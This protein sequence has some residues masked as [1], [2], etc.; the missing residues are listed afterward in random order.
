MVLVPFLLHQLQVY[1]HS[2]DEDRLVDIKDTTG[3]E[4][5]LDYLYDVW[6]IDL[7]IVLQ[8]VFTIKVSLEKLGDL[9][10]GPCEELEMRVSLQ[11]VIEE[12][13]EEVHHCLSFFVMNDGGPDG[14]DASLDMIGV[15]A[16]IHEVLDAEL[17]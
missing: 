3:G 7:L 11:V 1:L 2:L 16:A 14:D 10:S 4:Q 9:I 8:V 17:G 5:L 12:V 15:I 6:D 13:I